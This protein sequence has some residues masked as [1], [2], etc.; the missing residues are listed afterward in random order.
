M[1]MIGQLIGAIIALIGLGIIFYLVTV[2]ANRGEDGV[3]EVVTNVVGEVVDTVTAT[4]RVIQKE[5]KAK[6]QKDRE[7]LEEL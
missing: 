1:E 5:K 3:K 7:E 4:A 2:L 6:Q